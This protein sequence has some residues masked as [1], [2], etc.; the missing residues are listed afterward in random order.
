MLSALMMSAIMPLRDIR[1]NVV[2]AQWSLY[3]VLFTLGVFMLSIIM[4]TAPYTE[5]RYANCYYVECRG[6]PKAD[7]FKHRKEPQKE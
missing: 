3:L 5:C 7:Y 6:A 2:Y 1:L 4:F